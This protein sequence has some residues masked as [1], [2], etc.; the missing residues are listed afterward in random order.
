MPEPEPSEGRVVSL[1][2]ARIK[3]SAEKG[4]VSEKN[5]PNLVAQNFN[6]FKK[7]GS[8]KSTVFSG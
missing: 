4:C 2:N 8:H 5:Q 7:E 3:R 1:R 6:P